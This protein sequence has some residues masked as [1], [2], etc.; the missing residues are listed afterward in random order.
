MVSKKPH[1]APRRYLVPR[2]YYSSLYEIAKAMNSS[3]QVSEVMRTIVE[4]TAN[5]V[6]AKGCAV[7]L[8]SPD[9]KRLWRGST[10][11]LSESYLQKGPVFTIA[12]IG[13]CI[14]ERHPIAVL[15]A[16]EDELIQY[17]EEAKKEGIVSML[18]VPMELRDEIIGVLTVCTSDP[19]TFQDEDVDFL[20]AIA[21][22]AAV[23]L[24]NARLYEWVRRNEIGVAR[25]LLDWYTSWA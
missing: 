17:R 20:K 5:A 4:S 11:G 25:D 12:G 7:A 9:R 1:P 8:L 3:L 22:L 15:K 23:A 6:D 24:A 19:R 21:D 16:S 10:Y 18:F 13:K 14:N 2:K